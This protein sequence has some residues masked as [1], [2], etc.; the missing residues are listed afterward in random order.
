MRGA[1]DSLSRVVL[2]LFQPSRPFFIE[3]VKVVLRDKAWMGVDPTVAVGLVEAVAAAA[4]AAAAAAFFSMSEESLT[5]VL[6]DVPESRVLM[7]GLLILT[8]K[9]APMR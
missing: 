9:T 2:E 3:G 8:M 7:T 5:V 6:E 1:T 4:A